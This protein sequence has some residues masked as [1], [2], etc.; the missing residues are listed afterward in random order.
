MADPPEILPWNIVDFLS[1]VLGIS[2]DAVQ[3]SWLSLRTIAWEHDYLA[4][5][6]HAARVKHIEAF[7]RYGLIQNRGLGI[8][9][10]EPPMRTCPDRACGPTMRSNTHEVLERDLVE[11]SRLQVTLFTQEFGPVPG[12]ANSTYCRK[13]YTHYFHNYHVQGNVRRYY[14]HENTDFIQIGT[15]FYVERSLCELFAV[16]MATAW[17]SSTNCARIYH[18]GMVKSHISS[19]L[20]AD[21]RVGFEMDVKAV[22][23]SFFLHSLLLDN[24]RRG[25]ILELPHQASSPAERLRP[26]LEQRNLRMAGTGQDEWNHGCTTCCWFDKRDDGTMTVVRSTVT[27]GVTLGRP[28]CGVHDCL[29]RLPNVKCR[30]CKKHENLDNICAVKQCSETVSN[31]YRTCAEPTHRWLET[32]YELA[33]KG[34]FQLKRR[35]QRAQTSQPNDALPLGT[36]LETDEEILE[37]DGADLNEP[38]EFDASTIVC[39]GKPD[40]GNRVVRARFGRSMTHNEELCVS[41]C[42]IILGR[43]T[44][45]GSEAPNA[46]VQFWEALF[47]T[48]KSL[49]QVLWHDNNCRIM[50][51]L[52]NE[53]KERQ[54]YFADV[55]KP[56]DVFHFKCKHKEGDLDCGRDCNALLW[57]ELSVDGKWRFNSSA[58]EQTNA[59]FGG[60]QSIVREMPVERYEFFL[61]EMIRRRNIWMVKLLA[62]RGCHPHSIPRE[63]LL[64]DN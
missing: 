21:W 28:C 27:D 64:A 54:D 14:M 26:A 1:D 24:Q 44:F 5:E 33:G 49:P 18:E 57:P 3:N 37:G 20:P 23:N 38:V 43:A 56:V 52:R 19:L 9:S 16:M 6:A 10:L 48:K 32:Y 7:L 45:Y 59:W 4:A 2:G 13:C 41:S 11:P 36:I 61:D 58:A 40:T 47:P 50:A 12:F 22:S 35:L 51:M 60:F 42:G 25:T 31:G 63:E 15:H 29:E 8:Y 53:P 55:A 17:T 34:M 46:V 62:N 30:F 39:D